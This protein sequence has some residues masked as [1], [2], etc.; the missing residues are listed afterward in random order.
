MVH[1]FTVGVLCL[2]GLIVQWSFNQHTN[3]VKLNQKERIE[4]GVLQ[5]AGSLTVEEEDG[6]LVEQ[7]GGKP[8]KRKEVRGGKWDNLATEGIRG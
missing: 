2:W 6:T 5:M 8:R 1:S 7:D 4:G 3:L